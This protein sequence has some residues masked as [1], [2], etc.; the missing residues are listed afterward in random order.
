MDRRRLAVALMGLLGLAVAVRLRRFG[1][2]WNFWAVDY[3]SYAFVHRDELRGGHVAWVRLMGLHPPQ[4]ALLNAAISAAGGTL[5]ELYGLALLLSVGAGAVGAVALRRGGLLFAA[6][7]AISPLQAHY[8]LELNNYPLFLLGTALV[9]AG[10]IGEDR[11]G[12]LGALG[13]GALLSLH[14]HLAGFGLV[15]VT[16]LWL[17]LARRW[18]GVW[19]LGGAG[20]LALP[21]LIAALGQRAGDTT[22][23]NE[24][25]PLA[26]LASELAAAFSAYGGALSWASITAAVL[27]AA[28]FARGDRAG[29]FL[30]VFGLAGAGAVAAGIISGAAFV[31][32]TPYWLQPSWAALAV[33]ARGWAVG[34]KRQRAVLLGLLAPWVGLSAVRAV[35]PPVELVEVGS[36]SPQGWRL[37]PLDAPRPRPNPAPDANAPSGPAWAPAGFPRELTSDEAH[38]PLSWWAARP[39]PGRDGPRVMSVAAPTDPAPIRAFLLPRTASDV[40]VYLWDIAFVN[41]LPMRADPLF[42]AFHPAELGDF[43]SHEDPYPGYCRAWRGGTACFV[44]RAS[45]RGG[46]AE[47]ALQAALVRWLGEGRTV[48]LVWA[49][50]D[51][52]RVPPDPRAI[53]RAVATAGGSWTDAFFGPTWAVEVAPR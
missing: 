44:S 11:R 19:V 32:Q 8:G 37:P 21:V 27:G 40:A 24:R 47:A 41:D 23:H 43:R 10:A 39:I 9:A 46:D 22:F 31:R 18:R 29:R 42:A 49:R 52:Q 48:R 4:W 45:L 38:V 12:G 13:I 53:R 1:V 33:V 3:A 6:L 15:G 28:W 30:A 5:R 17:A 35:S 36:L 51:P 7:F 25:L 20:V 34:T 50:L 26:E 2:S 14:G 16:G